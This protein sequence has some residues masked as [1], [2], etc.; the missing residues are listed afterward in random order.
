MPFA[1]AEVSA[2]DGEADELALLWGA[3]KARSVTNL[4]PPD[5][6][7]ANVPTLV[8]FLPIHVLLI[9]KILLL[10]K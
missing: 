6:I 9:F 5:A 2:T 4:A 1:L 3:G 8:A 10:V 7:A